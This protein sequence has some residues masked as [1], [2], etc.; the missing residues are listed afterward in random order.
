MIVVAEYRDEA[1]SGASTVNRLGLGRLMRDAREKA[2][3]VVLCEALDRLSRDQAD[4][5]TIR[6]NLTFLDVG[7]S[8]VADGEVGAI[9]VGLKGL[10]S[11]LFLADLAQKTRRGL[12]ARVTAGSSAGGR[13][14]GY[15]V[16]EGKV[17]ELEI[18]EA[19]AEVVRRMFAEYTAGR[20][21]RAIVADLNREGVVAP[22]G[23]RW[24]ASTINGNRQRANGVI[25]NRLY[26]GEM[27]WNRQRFIKDPATGRRVSRANATE[28][29]VTTAVPHLAIVPREIFD[30]AQAIKAT[31]RG[32]HAVHSRKPR[33][34]FTGLIKCGCCGASFT[35]LYRDRLGCSG[36]RERGDCDNFRQVPRTVIE[37]RV[38]AALQEKLADPNLIAA[39][40][41]EYIA[42]R[43]RLTA[44]DR[45][46]ESG[47]RRRLAELEAGIARGVDMLL[48]GKAPDSM[49]ERVRGM[50]VEAKA[51]KADLASNG[52]DKDPI[53]LHP[54][55]AEKYRRIVA[56]LRAHVDELPEG[57]GRDAI[58]A[59]V[60]GLV[61]R[62][63]I[64]R[65]ESKKPATITVH[66]LLAEL[67]LVSRGAPL[68]K[69]NIGC[70][71]A[72]PSIPFKF[73][74]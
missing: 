39:Y 9:H 40:M 31:K 18:V 11:E 29:W 55:T 64:G 50:E 21:P 47:K 48:A 73:A 33:H 7:I 36:V 44:A 65:V 61:D 27:V 38:L 15:R 72:L 20:T 30:A 1:V 57:D 58:F 26:V 46:N 69:G 4:M 66:G 67:L 16:V 23:G 28:D 13:S 34:V 56:D 63:E 14:F 32:Q 60:R 17:G 45:A 35:M 62:I 59:K 8:T 6:K 5:A 52:S 54:G 37:D 41:R 25:M 42:E 43:N 24:N 53:Q 49:A 10:M 2:F 71:D 51:I 19:E 70:G 3:D 68:V 74:A 22:H 12:R